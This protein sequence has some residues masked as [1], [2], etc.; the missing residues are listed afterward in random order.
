MRDGIWKWVKPGSVKG[1]Q[2]FI[3]GREQVVGPE[4]QLGKGL[5]SPSYIRK[6]L[7]PL[8][9]SVPFIL[10]P[11][12]DRNWPAVLASVQ[13]FADGSACDCTGVLQLKGSVT[14]F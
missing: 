4:N 2:L 7:R 13:N 9:S 5:G 14:S 12:R 10:P 8:Y 1:T 3:C 6:E 11:I